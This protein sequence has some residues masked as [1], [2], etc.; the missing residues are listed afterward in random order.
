MIIQPLDYGLDPLL[1]FPPIARSYYHGWQVNLTSRVHQNY[2][3]INTSDR[4]RP[5]RVHVCMPA[6]ALPIY[7][8]HNQLLSQ[9]ELPNHRQPRSSHSIT[10]AALLRFA[11][12]PNTAAMEHYA[13]SACP[14]RIHIID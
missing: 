9:R 6:N 1:F 7:A 8:G 10:G 4:P 3:G 11:F 2:G 5:T 12:A 14:R 13:A